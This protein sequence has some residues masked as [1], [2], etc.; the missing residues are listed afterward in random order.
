MENAFEM[1]IRF[2]KWTLEY[3]VKGGHSEQAHSIFVRT[4]KAESEE[5]VIAEN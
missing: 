4:R 2:S 3:I 5:S 1:R